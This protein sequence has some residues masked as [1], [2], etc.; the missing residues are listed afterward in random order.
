MKY[1]GTRKGSEKCDET[2]LSLLA[3]RT[4]TLIYNNPILHFSCM[5][6]TCLIC[7][8]ESEKE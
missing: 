6:T 1:I 8:Y 2:R 3:L 7:M 5:L 4:T